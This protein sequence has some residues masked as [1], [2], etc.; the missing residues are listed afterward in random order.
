MSDEAAKLA[1]LAA[2]SPPTDSLDP[3]IAVDLDDVLSQTNRMVAQWHNDKF[4]TEMDLS[5]FYYFYY[6][7]NPFWG[8]PQET[9]EKV[10]ETRNKFQPHDSSN[11]YLR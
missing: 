7:K 3:V 8:T 6:W 5:Q 2:L 4:G 11:L 10:N 1:K 9:Y